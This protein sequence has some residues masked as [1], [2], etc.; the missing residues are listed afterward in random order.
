MDL[1]WEWDV[2]SR[3]FQKASWCTLP[4]LTN[5]S[6]TSGRGTLKVIN[7]ILVCFVWTWMGTVLGLPRG[8]WAVQGTEGSSIQVQGYQLSYEIWASSITHKTDHD[9]FVFSKIK[10]LLSRNS[11]LNCQE[12]GFCMSQL[13]NRQLEMKTNSW[14]IN[15]KCPHA[16]FYY[17]EITTFFT[18]N[19][20]LQSRICKTCGP[21]FCFF[22]CFHVCMSSFLKNCT[23]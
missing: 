3:F 15:D 13:A 18:I 4:W 19:C 6:V 1:V 14:L 21:S 8:H 16:T 10:Q 11:S 12:T 2:S 7:T 9:F 17:Q 5:N 20:I 22:V 23:Q